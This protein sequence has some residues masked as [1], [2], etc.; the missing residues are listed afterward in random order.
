MT[1]SPLTCL[2]YIDGNW[3][4]SNSDRTAESRNPADEREVVATFPL[5]DGTDVEKAIGA[6]REAYR[7][8]R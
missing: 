3:T 7:Q 4:A 5:S 8:W 6:A 1:S 2:N